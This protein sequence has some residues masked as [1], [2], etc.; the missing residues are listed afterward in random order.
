MQERQASKLALVTCQNYPS[1]SC[2][3]HTHN[4][5]PK[6]SYQFPWFREEQLSI[7]TAVSV[8]GQNHWREGREAGLTICHMCVFLSWR[9]EF[10]AG[11]VVN[12]T[13]VYMGFTPIAEPAGCLAINWWEMTRIHLEISLHLV[14]VHTPTFL[15]WLN[16]HEN[17][18]KIPS[19]LLKNFVQFLSSQKVTEYLIN[20]Q[21]TGRAGRKPSDLL[22]WVTLDVSS[23]LFQQ[24]RN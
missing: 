9:L 15:D 1:Q 18:A 14:I 10:K 3:K 4:C 23:A 17:W 13:T 16:Y 7:W 22:S 12:W 6:P 8:S 21:G 5:I 24:L 19:L 2:R 11:A 20:V